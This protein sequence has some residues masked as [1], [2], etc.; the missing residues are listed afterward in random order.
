MGFKVTYPCSGQDWRMD[1]RGKGNQLIWVQN[2]GGQGIPGLRYCLDEFT[3]HVTRS[4]ATK[5]MGIDWEEERLAGRIEYATYYTFW[6]SRR[7]T[8]PCRPWPPK[9][10]QLGLGIRT[11]VTFETVAGREHK[12]RRDISGS[13]S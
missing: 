12:M 11:L 9:R 5:Q 4:F 13:L 8:S 7:D 2:A 6:G 1:M 3:G 10:G